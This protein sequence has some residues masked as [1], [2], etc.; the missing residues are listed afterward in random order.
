LHGFVSDPAVGGDEVE[1]IAQSFDQVYS[2]KNISKF[3]V[4]KIYCSEYIASAKQIRFFEIES[5]LS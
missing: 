1:S 5:C 3:V 4:K 2:N